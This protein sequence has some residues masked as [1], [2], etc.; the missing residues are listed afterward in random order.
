MIKLHFTKPGLQT[1]IVD[2][3]RSGYQA[4]GVPVGGALDQTS[5]GM[6]NW[7]VGNSLSTPLL[8]ITLMGPTIE[9]EGEGQMALAGA[10]LSPQIDD[11][12]ISMYE[13]IDLQ[14]GMKLSFGAPKR[15]CRSYLA[16]NG[17]WQVQPWLAS[18]SALA[19]D[20]SGITADSTI[21]KNCTISIKPENDIAKKRILLNQ[22][23]EFPRPLVIRILP[24]P[25]YDS[26]SKDSL[27]QL[28]NQD[29]VVCRHSNRMGCRLTPELTIQSKDEMISSGI[30]PGTIQITPSG[31][32]VVLLADAQTSGGYPRIANVITGDLDKLG[33]L[34]PGDKMRF[35]L[36]ELSDAREALVENQ[37]VFG[38]LN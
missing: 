34:K 8:E 14:S 6:A 11:K 10:D 5:A 25:E 13:T 15:G 2:K 9:V 26:F 30:V 28:L 4:W 38:F 3:G 18:Y 23:P 20:S 32:P 21:K 36:V 1:L 19:Y 33:Q 37:K 22:I 24:G 29:F 7:L 12:E 35:E 17:S 31:Q 16:I 27:D